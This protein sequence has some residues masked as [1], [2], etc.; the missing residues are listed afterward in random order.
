MV[1][2]ENYVSILHDGD[3]CTDS[4]NSNSEN[5]SNKFIWLNFEKEKKIYL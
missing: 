3:Y 2:S 5:D 4:N 1:L